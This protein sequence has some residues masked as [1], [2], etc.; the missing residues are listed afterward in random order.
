[1]GGNDI[2][3]VGPTGKLLASPSLPAEDADPF[4]GHLPLGSS[5]FGSAVHLSPFFQ[6][7]VMKV[8]M[9]APVAR[10]NRY[11]MFLE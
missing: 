1:M 10:G 11:R 9:N 5:A 2:W 6:D 4:L 3:A 7:T 8:P